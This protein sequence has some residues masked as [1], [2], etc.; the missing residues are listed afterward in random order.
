MICGLGIV[1]QNH[2]LTNLDVQALFKARFEQALESQKLNIKQVEQQLRRM[3]VNPED[4]VAVAS[5]QRVASTFFNAIDRK[6]GSPYVFREEKQ[7]FTQPPENW[8]ESE[9]NIDSDQEELDRFIAEIEDAADKEWVA[10]EAAEKEE[11]GQIRYWNREEFGG[12]FRRSETQGDDNFY[13]NDEVKRARGW[14]ETRGKQRTDD[15]YENDND[16][17]EGEDE[18]DSDDV[19]DASGLESDADD[20]NQV[21]DRARV[22]RAS[23]SRE[24]NVHG[25]KNNRSF[26][27]NSEANF[28]RKTT[29]E[30][31]D[32]EN[33]LSDLESARW[34]SDAKEEHDSHPSRAANYDYRSSSDEEEDLYHTTGNEKNVVSEDESGADDSDETQSGYN[35]SKVAWQKRDRISRV[36]NAEPFVRKSEANFRGKIAEEDSGSEDTFSNL[37]N[38]M[39]ESD[40]E[41]DPK[42]SVAQR[43][44]TGDEENHHQEK[45]YGV[46]DEKTKTRKEKD[47]AWDSD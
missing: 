10:E 36:T 35:I 24:D 8:E 15:S 20:S 1:L 14:K 31:S 42:T 17:S 43:Y 37:E 18:W 16:I 44:S 23:R 32:S 40:A 29:E 41:D 6:E 7:Q 46:D 2:K 39:W 26:K 12:R 27:I 11:R 5:I 34:Q 47:E 30:D 21:L 38:E 22:S 45:S 9:P 13:G 19:R 25:F 3:G 33:M 28:R 4:P